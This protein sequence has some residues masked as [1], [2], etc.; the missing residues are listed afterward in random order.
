LLN[1][2]G[3]QKQAVKSGSSARP[4]NVSPAGDPG[5]HASPPATPQG[6]FRVNSLGER[7]FHHDASAEFA[8]GI[9]V[10]QD[11][12]IYR[13]SARAST[14]AGPPSPG[15]VVVR[16]LPLFSVAKAG[17]CTMWAGLAHR[18]AAACVRFHSV[19]LQAHRAHGAQIRAV[20]SLHPERNP[21]TQS[22]RTHDI[23]DEEHVWKHHSYINSESDQTGPHNPAQ[24]SQAAGK[25][26]GQTHADPHRDAVGVGPTRGRVNVRQHAQ[27]SSFDGGSF[28]LKS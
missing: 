17:S 8:S 16:K 23:H 19:H 4:L 15:Q 14:P 9:D 21:N 5:A 11:R 2:N 6:H 22:T 10:P 26:C 24:A 12:M 1:R 27:A 7:S 18:V 25:A 20:R 13:A 28:V 3:T